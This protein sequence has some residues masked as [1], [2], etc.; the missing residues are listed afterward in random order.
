[1]SDDFNSPP[2]AASI[3]PIARL[4]PVDAIPSTGISVTVD[5]SEAELK[6]IAKLLGILSV[7]SLHAELAA[8]REGDRVRVKGIVR[9]AATQACVV[10][11]DP[12]SET[13]DEAVEVVFA[14]REEAEALMRK[15]G[16]PDEDDID[17]IGLDDVDFAAFDLDMLNNPDALPEPILDG[18]IDFG[19]IA[20]DA[21]AVGL[22]PYPRKPGVVFEPPAEE[23]GFGS[24]FAALKSLKP[25]Q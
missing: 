14:P 1:M 9:A 21:L 4:Q 6:A 18:A 7:E 2:R 15:A 5:A 19:Q 25:K 10:T 3:L 20:Y 12:V 16:L 22:D 11:L 24:P 8:A 23:E 13:V 17:R